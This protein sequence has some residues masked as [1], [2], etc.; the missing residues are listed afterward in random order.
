MAAPGLR[1]CTRALPSCGKRGPLFIAASGSY[2]LLRC[3]DL[4]PPRPLLL[5]STGSRHAGPSSCGVRAQQLRLLGSRVQAQQLWHTGLFA[6]W[7]V[8]SSQTRDRTCVPY[9]GRRTP[10]HC[11]TREA[12]ACI[13]I[14]QFEILHIFK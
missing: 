7:H 14:N 8:G 11:A 5:R 13:S 10:N 9:I 1:R 12:Q 2:S 3:V 6:P 4:S